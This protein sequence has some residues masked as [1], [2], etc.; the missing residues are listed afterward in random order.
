MFLLPGLCGSSYVS[1]LL[2]CHFGTVLEWSERLCP[3]SSPQEVLW[4]KHNSQLL[5]CAFYFHR[6]FLE[7]SN[8]KMFGCVPGMFRVIKSYRYMESEDSHISKF[9][10]V[11]MDRWERDFPCHFAQVEQ[12]NCRVHFTLY[13]FTWPVT[14]LTSTDL[15]SRPRKVFKSHQWQSAT[16]RQVT[17]GSL[18]HLVPL[19]RL[20]I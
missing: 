11:V 5:G 14:P 3:G 10:I 13:L 20:L 9:R 4:I 2:L 15:L 7:G 12:G 1:W 6:Q 16:F 18:W 8:L 19:W 17:L